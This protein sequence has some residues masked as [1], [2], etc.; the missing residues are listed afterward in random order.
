MKGL[1]PRVWIVLALLLCSFASAQNV[2]F[3]QYPTQVV[4]GLAYPVFWEANGATV[5]IN[6][7][8]NGAQQQTLYTGAG[9]TF[10][11]QTEDDD[12]AGT[13]YALQIVVGGAAPA[14]IVS[15][16][17]WVIEDEDG[18]NVNGQVIYAS[19][20]NGPASSGLVS[21][22]APTVAPP[23]S[24]A[25]T[26]VASSAPASAP[27]SASQSASGSSSAF[28]PASAPASASASASR[29]ETV[30]FTSA[31]SVYTFTTTISPPAASNSM[32]GVETLTF[33]SAGATFTTTMGTTASSEPTVNP[34]PSI[35]SRSGLSGGAIAGI[36]IGLLAL[37]ALVAGLLWFRRRR[38]KQ[39]RM[40]GDTVPRSPIMAFISGG[41]RALSDRRSAPNA[42]SAYAVT[43]GDE[44][45]AQRQ[46]L[47]S[48]LSPGTAT[49]LDTPTNHLGTQG[50]G[51]TFASA[52]IDG[53]GRHEMQAVPLSYELAAE[54]V[55][56][57]RGDM[58]RYPATCV[59]VSRVGTTSDVSASQNE[60]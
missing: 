29:A 11:W 52:E 33:V 2:G 48:P 55:P 22:A 36:V 43:T 8:Q 57:A 21:A 50:T 40:S 49:E 44:K 35:P 24:A 7:L 58:T 6:L 38:Q 46:S 23:A 30:T 15:G 42:D 1:P 16:A 41:R 27:A 26:N 13:N 12:D 3:T 32:T 31:Q 34:V 53:Q 19:V 51:T 9:N 5:T 54:D 25:S 47:V 37:I 14:N 4:S 39:R 60:K 17:I 18:L 20:A 10:T 28:A 56:I 59:S 45:Q